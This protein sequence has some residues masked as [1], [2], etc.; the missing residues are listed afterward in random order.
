MLSKNKLKSFISEI[1]RGFSIINSGFGTVYVKHL[2][3]LESSASDAVYEDFLNRAVN[4]KILKID[5]REKAI[6]E[7]GS[8]TE[9]QNREISEL[10]NYIENL[11]TTKKQL[12]REKEIDAINKTV[13][14]NEDKLEKLLLEKNELIGL[15]A[16]SYAAKRLNEFYVYHSTYKDSQLTKKF[17]TQEE[18]DESDD[19]DISGLVNAYNESMRTFITINFKKAALSGYFFNIYNLSNDDPFIFFGKPIVDLS[20]YQIELY[21]YGK[22]FK[23]LLSN[24]KGQPPAEVMDDPDKLVEWCDS[25]NNTDRLLNQNG[26]N[27][28]VSYKSVVGL[29]QK[30]RKRLGMEQ[31]Q[32]IDLAKEAEKRGGKLNLTEIIR[33]ENS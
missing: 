30:D 2:T 28:D 16:E 6:V 11:K 27:G 22:Y 33:L 9:K 32:G 19:K 15:T 21:S 17:F 13:K 14:E 10:K 18:F 4:N 29:S 7:D 1:I 24:A 25:V 26:D 8:W 31:T 5:E 3:L 12:F 20:F 23:S